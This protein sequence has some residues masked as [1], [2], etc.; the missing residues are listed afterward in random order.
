VRERDGVREREGILL[1]SWLLLLLLLLLLR[2]GFIYHSD[3]C[4]LYERRNE[5]YI[6]GFCVGFGYGLVAIAMRLS[7][8][9]SAS[10]LTPQPSTQLLPNNSLSHLN[11]NSN[12]VDEICCLI[13]N[14]D[15]F[16]NKRCAIFHS[17]TSFAPKSEIMCLLRRKL[18]MMIMIMASAQCRHRNYRALLS[19]VEGIAKSMQ[20]AA[21]C[22]TFFF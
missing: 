11:S 17:L 1:V 14:L 15:A 3:C 8:R 7:T 16:L 22:K 5:F 19:M 12:I 9:F 13:C 6:F 20:H 2:S 18:L 10:H 21:G 4:W